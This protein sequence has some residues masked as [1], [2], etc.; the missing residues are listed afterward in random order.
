MEF[1]CFFFFAGSAFVTYAGLELW[2]SF[3]FW[4]SCDESM[5][6]VSDRRSLPYV[7]V[8]MRVINPP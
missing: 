7:H 6:N 3:I 1:F 8:C 2:S 5:D 4:T